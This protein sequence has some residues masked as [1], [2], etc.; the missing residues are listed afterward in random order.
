MVFSTFCNISNLALVTH[1]MYLCMNVTVSYMSLLLLVWFSFSSQVVFLC[2][3]TCLVIFS[4]LPSIVNCILL[5]AVRVWILINKLEVYSEMQLT[6]IETVV[7]FRVFLLNLIRQ[8]N[9][10][11]SS[12]TIFELLQKEY[13][14]FG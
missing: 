11:F 8:N 10:N 12:M 2:F 14:F 4:W 6:Y 5:E 3:F 13:N 9:S 1:L 7:S